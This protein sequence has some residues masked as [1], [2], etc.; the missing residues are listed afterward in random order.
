MHTNDKLWIATMIVAF[1]MAVALGVR[2]VRHDTKLASARAALV[3]TQAEVDDL[4]H[5]AVVLGYA[6]RGGTRHEFAWKRV[7]R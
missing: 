1:I 3:A 6:E 7:G 5:D 4:Q 2:E